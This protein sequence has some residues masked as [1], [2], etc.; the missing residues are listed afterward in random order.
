MLV[1]SALDFGGTTFQR[2]RGVFNEQTPTIIIIIVT[3]TAAAVAATVVVAAAA[4]ATATITT[5]ATTTDRFCI[6]LLSALEHTLRFTCFLW[7]V[8]SFLFRFVL[9]FL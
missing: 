5:T 8:F 7:V 9:P 3:T 4:A 2:C 1:E 6:V